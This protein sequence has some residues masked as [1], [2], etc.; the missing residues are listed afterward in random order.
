MRLANTSAVGGGSR[1][2]G[3][4]AVS[5]PTLQGEARP[6]YMYPFHEGHGSRDYA[7]TLAFMASCK[8][9]PYVSG[10]ALPGAY[11]AL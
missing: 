5:R 2:Q 3:R 9:T 8:H 10:G 7:C 6:S 11:T 4:L 1:C